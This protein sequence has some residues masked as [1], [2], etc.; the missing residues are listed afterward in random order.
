[1]EAETQAEPA[2][3]PEASAP[4]EESTRASEFAEA[5]AE[6][7]ARDDGDEA[8]EDICRVD[9]GACPQMDMEAAPASPASEDDYEVEQSGKRG[10]GCRFVGREAHAPALVLV[11]GAL[12]AA[13]W[14]RRRG[15]TMTPPR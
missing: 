15:R 1:M 12:G 14:R 7:E 9:P 3:P 2:P 13:L 5:D 10:C 11:L 4:R 6:E 8:L